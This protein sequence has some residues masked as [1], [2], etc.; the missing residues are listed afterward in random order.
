MHWVFSKFWTWQQTLSAC[1]GV[2]LLC[3]S[4]LGIF[5]TNW[6]FGLHKWSELHVS[7][8][9]TLKWQKIA[10]TLRTFWVSH[11]RRH[12]DWSVTTRTTTRLR[13]STTQGPSESSYQSGIP[14][15]IPKE[16]P[17][18]FIKGA[19]AIPGQS[20]ME[21]PQVIAG[22]SQI[23]EETEIMDEHSPPLYL[24]SEYISFQSS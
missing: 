20:W 10:R 8:V 23:G 16:N 9:L 12:P 1:V 17:G 19:E 22:R 5:E 7:R 6:W 2:D 13:P 24:L 18:H 3:C 21:G 4:L 11:Q 14:L 15:S